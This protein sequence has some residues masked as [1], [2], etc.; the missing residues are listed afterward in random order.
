MIGKIEEGWIGVIDIELKVKVP[1]KRLSETF[2]INEVINAYLKRVNLNLNYILSTTERNIEDLT[3]MNHF[4][5]F[6][7][8]T[9]CCFN[10]CKKK[11]N[12]HV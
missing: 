12:K 7:Q 11:P 9:F 1:K 10:G 2:L 8:E 6:Y 4:S 5:K 3:V